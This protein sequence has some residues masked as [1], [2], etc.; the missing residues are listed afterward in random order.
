[1]TPR[2]KVLRTAAS[3]HVDDYI[4]SD[5]QLGD[6]VPMPP[7]GEAEV[8]VESNTEVGA[9][10]AANEEEEETDWR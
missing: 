7:T 10:L 8:K 5:E 3:V 4:D 2:S 9:G 6:V 1:M